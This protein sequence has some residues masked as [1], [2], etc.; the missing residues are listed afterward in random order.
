MA[1]LSGKSAGR[2]AELPVASPER[3]SEPSGLSSRRMV[4]IS[5]ASRDSMAATCLASWSILFSSSPRR[6]SSP[7]G[8]GCCGGDAPAVTGLHDTGSVTLELD[9]AE[10]RGAGSAAASPRAGVVDGAVPSPLGDQ[11]GLLRLERAIL[12]DGA[13]PV[14]DA[15]WRSSHVRPALSADAP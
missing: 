7:A 15:L 1:L 13:C 6:A 2:T 5:S 10:A 3:R 12:G 9:C 14:E 8:N 4:C 11:P